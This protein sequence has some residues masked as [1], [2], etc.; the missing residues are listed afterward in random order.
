[1]SE[2]KLDDIIAL[3]LIIARSSVITAAKGKESQNVAVM[4]FQQI[5][6]IEDRQ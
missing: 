6:D 3:L 2:K 4:S 1:M 5:S